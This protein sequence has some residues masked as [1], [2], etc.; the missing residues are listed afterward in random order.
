MTTSTTHRV[1]GQSLRRVEGANKVTG[2]TIFT[3]D[4]AMPGLAFVKLVLAPHPHARIGDIDVEAALA[5]PGVIAV[6]T[7]AD[8]PALNA[9]DTD[10]PLAKGHVVYVGQPVA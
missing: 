10:L 5:A 7:A 1:I 6:V 9:A 4:L 2:G 8:L 3:A